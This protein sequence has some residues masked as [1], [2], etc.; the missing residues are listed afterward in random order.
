MGAAPLCPVERA[1]FSRPR[2]DAPLGCGFLQDGQRG[3]CAPDR[4]G[5]PVVK[6]SGPRSQSLGGILLRLSASPSTTSKHAA[7]ACRSDCS[8]VLKGAWEGHGVLKLFRCERVVRATCKPRIR[9]GRESQSRPAKNRKL[10]CGKTT[11]KKTKHRRG[12]GRK[13]IPQRVNPSH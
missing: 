3:I 9:R 1:R 6:L 8:P 7:A 10:P 2:M 5:P 4:G 12:G 13:W 11:T